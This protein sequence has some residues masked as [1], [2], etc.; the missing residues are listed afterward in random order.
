MS[1]E[2]AFQKVLGDRAA[3]DREKNAIT[4]KAVG[5][6]R[7]R[8]DFLADAAFAADQHGCRCRRD[9]L[10]HVCDFLHR[11]AASERPVRTKMTIDLAAQ[12]LIFPGKLA[13]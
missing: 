6:N 2:L 4:G 9:F 12:D 5:M 8:H 13:V 7:S 11:R 1:E 10:D 3:I